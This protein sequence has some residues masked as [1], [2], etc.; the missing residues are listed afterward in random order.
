VVI[1]GPGLGEKSDILAEGA[2]LPISATR[3]ASS[4]IGDKPDIWAVA[5][6]VSRPAVRETSGTFVLCV[7]VVGV[8]SPSVIHITESVIGVVGL[9]VGVA[10][11]ASIG[12]AE[13]IIGV[14]GLA[15]EVAMSAIGEK[16][17]N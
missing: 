15:I 13:L 4:A 3:I 16:P 10:E 5:T 7:L 2:G 9:A 6:E 12:K 17:G 8:V 11:L 1:A 14:A